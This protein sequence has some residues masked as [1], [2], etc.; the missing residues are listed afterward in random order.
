M[1]IIRKNRENT[2]SKLNIFPIVFS[3]PNVAVNF[4][5]NLISMKYVKL[6]FDY[7]SITLFV[8]SANFHRNCCSKYFRNNAPNL[9]KRQHLF[10]KLPKGNLNL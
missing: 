9:T 6:I 4:T 5:L 7:D 3:N 8:Y 2:E 10:R 1:C